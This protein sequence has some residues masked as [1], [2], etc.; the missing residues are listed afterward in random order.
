M[1]ITLDKVYHNI[2]SCVMESVTIVSQYDV[3]EAT[4]VEV[5]GYVLESW[6]FEEDEIEMF[7]NS[8][9]EPSRELQIRFLAQAVYS[10]QS[11]DE[12]LVPT[13]FLSFTQL[14]LFYADI[15]EEDIMEIF[16]ISEESWVKK[17]YKIYKNIEDQK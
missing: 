4:P 17:A 15:E 8:S 10:R 9:L 12:R 7:I 16:R 5:L 14:L 2:F 3:P 11:I 1:E 13:D 6:G